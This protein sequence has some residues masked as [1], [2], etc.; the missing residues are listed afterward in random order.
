MSLGD[1]MRVSAEK[2]YSLGAMTTLHQGTVGPPIDWLVSLVRR[3]VNHQEAVLGKDQ[4]SVDVE[5]QTSTEYSSQRT[6]PF[7][8]TGPTDICH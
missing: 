1:A 2:C 6:L 3:G 7:A 4:G 5:V 8:P